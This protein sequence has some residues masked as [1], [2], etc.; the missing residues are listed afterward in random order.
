MKE[1]MVC[2]KPISSLTK[3]EDAFKPEVKAEE[4][5][6]QGIVFD[7][8]WKYEE[9]VLLQ[10]SLKQIPAGTRDRYTA[11]HK[12]IIKYGAK[13]DYKQLINQIKEFQNVLKSGGNLL[14][15]MRKSAYTP[16]D[17]LIKKEDSNANSAVDNTE[18]EN[19]NENCEY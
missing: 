19:E 13:K 17:E 11:V 2:L 18:N 8:R 12:D 15:F 10:K 14:D 7:E 1:N 4:E 5:Y 16:Q 6:L 9:L 3:K